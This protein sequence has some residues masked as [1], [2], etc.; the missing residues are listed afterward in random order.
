[1]YY[2]Y[3]LEKNG[4]KTEDT[5]ILKVVKKK[6]IIM[7]YFYHQTVLTQFQQVGLILI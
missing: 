5:H 6:M 1:M 2:I 4:N 7:K 3:N